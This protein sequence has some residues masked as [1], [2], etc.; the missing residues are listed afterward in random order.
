ML[1]SEANIKTVLSAIQSAEGEG[2][3]CKEE[4]L[5]GEA[6]KIIRRKSSL[7]IKILTVIG[8]LMASSFL[9]NF[10]F[11][12]GLQKNGIGL[13]VVGVL[14]IF[15]T[16]LLIKYSGELFLETLC[17]AYFI[18]G[19]LL[20]GYG[21]NLLK[22]SENQLIV[23]YISISFCVFLLSKNY[24]MIL[25]SMLVFSAS[26]LS[27]IHLNK[28]DQLIHAYILI[29]ALGMVLFLLN[30][31]LF[32]T[33][34]R[35]LTT[36]YNPIRIGMILSLLMGLSLI[37]SKNLFPI[38]IQMIWISSVV[39]IGLILYLTN[40]ILIK[41]NVQKSNR[42]ILAFTGLIL[43]TTVLSPA[44][45]GAILIIMLCFSINFRPGIGLGIVATIYFIAQFYYDMNVSLFVKSMLLLSTG[46]LFILLYFFTKKYLLADEKI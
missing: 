3:V 23:Y 1:N 40:H 4:E 31:A 36:L 19:Y 34:F 38:N 17:V 21:C 16:L 30:E 15:G 24:L 10:I 35:Q 9:S 27:F 42:L 20:F 2:F 28:Y 45:S 12:T 18:T 37:G 33:K 5:M 7:M 8:A 29:Y 41:M 26:L 44:I 25:I 11:L 32:I 43:L 46:V 22:Q 13:L 39:C 14:M 6:I